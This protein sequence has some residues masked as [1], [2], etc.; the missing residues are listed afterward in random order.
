MSNCE[1]RKVSGE[2]LTPLLMYLTDIISQLVSMYLKNFDTPDLKVAGLEK[3]IFSP[4]VLKEP[5]ELTPC[6]TTCK[7]KLAK[8]KV[9]NMEMEVIAP[10]VSAVVRGYFVKEPVSVLLRKIS[11]EI[12]SDCSSYLKVV[13]AQVGKVEFITPSYFNPVGQALRRIPNILWYIRMGLRTHIVGRKLLLPVRV[14]GDALPLL[15]NIVT[16]KDERTNP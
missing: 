14:G 16:E 2:Q 3:I 9:K 1:R 12:E 7:C 11:L 4:P 8:F 13:N 6:L 5:A 10:N 15:C